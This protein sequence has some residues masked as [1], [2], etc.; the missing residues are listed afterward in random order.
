[1]VEQG[2]DHKILKGRQGTGGRVQIRLKIV[3]RGNK[4]PEN[5]EKVEF[6]LG[7]KDI[8]SRLRGTRD[9]NSERVLRVQT[10]RDR[11]HVKRQYET[12][13]QQESRAKTRR[14]RAGLFLPLDVISFYY[15]W[16]DR[17]KRQQDQ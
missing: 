4:R 1:M 2:K 12:S 10:R 3:T 15:L 6:K 16:F 5:S 9:Q 14:E 8:V 13:E 17:V 11:D 7:E